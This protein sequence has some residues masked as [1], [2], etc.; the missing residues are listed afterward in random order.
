MSHASGYYIII[1]D[2][3]SER[4]IFFFKFQVISFSMG[5]LCPL[6]RLSHALEISLSIMEL[7]WPEFLITPTILNCTRQL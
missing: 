3:G 1:C 4:G 6:Q 2:R 5:H 7:Q